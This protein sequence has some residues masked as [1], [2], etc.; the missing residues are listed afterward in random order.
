[1]LRS[2]DRCEIDNIHA[3]VT[4]LQLAI[5]V[6]DHVAMTDRS[7]MARQIKESASRL[8]Q[9]VHDEFDREQPESQHAAP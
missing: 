3:E 9:M 7:E 2:R 5:D 6:Y 8:Q 1:M 4:A